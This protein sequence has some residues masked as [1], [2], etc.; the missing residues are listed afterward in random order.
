VLEGAVQRAISVPVDGYVLSAEVRAGDVIG[1]GQEM[2]RLDD[3]ELV[4]ERQRWAAELSQ[5]A[6][7]Y[8]QAQAR[9]QRAEAQ[10]IRA[11]MAQA[12]AQ[13]ELL[14]EQLARMVLVAPFDAVVISGDLSQSIGKAVRRGEP[15]FEVAP[16]DAYRVVLKVD[17]TDIDELA[18]GQAGHLVISSMPD[19]R[20]ALVV[21]NVTPVSVSEEGRNY[22][23]VE[24]SSRSRRAPAPRHVGRRQG[25]GRRAQAHL[26]LD[27]RPV[28]WL[29]L[30]LWAWWR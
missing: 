12:E 4:L 14:D 27:A 15:L 17:E 20:F 22:F 28:D 9:G 10:I 30:K 25:R 18:A 11:Q 3:R 1:A 29:R 16:L 21:E 26:D 19:Q 23:R 13:L 7:E 24:A 5:R 2:A 8:D 6:L